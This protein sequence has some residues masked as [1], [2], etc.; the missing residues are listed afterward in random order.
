MGDSDERVT[1]DSRW[2][3]QQPGRFLLLAPDARSSPSWR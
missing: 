3:S 1:I 2:S